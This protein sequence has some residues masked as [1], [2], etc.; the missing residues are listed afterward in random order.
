[1]AGVMLVR[2]NTGKRLESEYEKEDPGSNNRNT[3]CADFTDI[4]CRM[5]GMM[6]TLLKS[7]VAWGKWTS[8]LTMR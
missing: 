4:Y 8:G 1:M 7:N 2:M 3:Q 6:E 5:Q